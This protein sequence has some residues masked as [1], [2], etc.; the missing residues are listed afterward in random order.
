M[1]IRDETTKIDI[2]S[3]QGIEYLSEKPAMQLLV[4]GED[5]T[6][7]WFARRFAGALLIAVQVGRHAVIKPRPAA[8][9]RRQ[10]RQ[11]IG[12]LGCIAGQPL[13]GC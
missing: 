11:R 1:G 2:S 8:V 12:R 6:D 10:G 9:A 5:S 13:S 7:L 4:K 3:K